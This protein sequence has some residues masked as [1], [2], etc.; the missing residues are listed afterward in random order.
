[1]KSRLSKP[2]LAWCLVLSAASAQAE[3]ETYVFDTQHTYPNFEVGHLG[4]S[5]R[6]GWFERTSGRVTIDRTT[7]KGEM[8]VEI[9]AASINT[10]LAVRDDFVRSDKFGFLDVA[11]YP[12]IVFRSTQFDFNGSDLK[13][14][15]GDLTI[16]GVTKPVLLDVAS[17][18]C[19]M[20][21]MKKVPL[22]GGEARAVIN[23]SDFGQFGGKMLG[24]EIRLSLEFEAYRE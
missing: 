17:L 12:K 13:R 3:P 8:Q 23:K 5:V 22:C 1:M 11:K 10:G 14:I 21:P 18:R 7:G 4:F 2:F 24:E 9:D 6:R 15:S 20:H 19:G 16:K